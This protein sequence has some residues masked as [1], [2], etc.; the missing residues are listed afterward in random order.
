[1]AC[2]PAL[3]SHYPNP[4]AWLSLPGSRYFF[5]DEQCAIHKWINPKK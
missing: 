2:Q 5:G 4:L 1:M 3:P